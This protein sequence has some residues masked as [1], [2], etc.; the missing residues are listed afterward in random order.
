[1]KEEIRYKYRKKIIP[2]WQTFPHWCEQHLLLYL[3]LC[4]SIFII[5]WMCLTVQMWRIRIERIIW[6]LRL[7][8]HKCFPLTFALIGVINTDFTSVKTQLINEPNS[9]HTNPNW[10]WL[11]TWNNWNLYCRR[12]KNH[13]ICCSESYHW[14]R[15]SNQNQW[16]HRNRELPYNL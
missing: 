4:L 3:Y 5:V 1:M 9:N 8:K 7:K 14:T 13:L 11:W 16:I 2:Q 12:G 15:T 10:K 6:Q